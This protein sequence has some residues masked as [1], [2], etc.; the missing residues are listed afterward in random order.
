MLARFLEEFLDAI[1]ISVVGYGKAG[2]SEFLRAGEEAGYR[3]VSV[4]D[5]ILGMD[6]KMNESHRGIC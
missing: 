1:H 5:G 3:R 4:E 2:H 6:V